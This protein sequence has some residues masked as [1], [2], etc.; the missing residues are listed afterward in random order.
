MDLVE[1]VKTFLILEIESTCKGKCSAR[2]KNL[3]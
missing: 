2:G 1:K 3:K